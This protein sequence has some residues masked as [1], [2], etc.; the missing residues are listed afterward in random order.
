MKTPDTLYDVHF[1]GG[2]VRMRVTGRSLRG[3]RAPKVD[4]LWNVEQ[5]RRATP[6]ELLKL[7]KGEQRTKG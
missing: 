7:C 6:E 1:K 5:K 3:L 4:W 2:G